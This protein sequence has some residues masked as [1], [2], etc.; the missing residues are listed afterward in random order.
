[1]K[2]TPGFKFANFPGID[3]M[4]VIMQS[5]NNAEAHSRL[6]PDSKILDLTERFGVALRHAGVGITVTS[7]TDVIAFAVGAS[8]VSLHFVINITEIFK[9]SGIERLMLCI[10]ISE[11]MRM[12]KNDEKYSKT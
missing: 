6:K 2:S 9:D 12:V 10:S 11:C 8:T 4:F 1:M 7:I 5:W 3:D